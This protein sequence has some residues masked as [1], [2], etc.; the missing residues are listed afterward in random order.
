MTACYTETQAPATPGEAGLP[1]VFAFHSGGA[2]PA[3]AWHLK[4]SFYT[5]EGWA[6]PEGPPGDPGDALPSTSDGG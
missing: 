3:E 1:I 4:P 5:R 6:D 2:D